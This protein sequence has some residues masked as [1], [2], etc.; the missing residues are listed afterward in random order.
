MISRKNSIGTWQKGHFDHRFS[1]P[2]YFPFYR[3]FGR[4][5]RLYGWCEDLTNSPWCVNNKELVKFKGNKR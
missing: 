5:H 3:V 2:Y 1:G 4:Y